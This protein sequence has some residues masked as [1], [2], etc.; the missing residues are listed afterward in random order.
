[1]DSNISGMTAPTPSL[2]TRNRTTCLAS[3]LQRFKPSSSAASTTTGRSSLSQV[4]NVA[5]VLVD[6]WDSSL[7]CNGQ[8]FYV[9]KHIF[10]TVF[11]R[12]R[13]VLDITSNTET[14]WRF[15]VVCWPP[16]TAAGG[17]RL[18]TV[19]W[20][21][22]PC[23]RRVG[24]LDYA[25]LWSQRCADNRMWPPAK[26]RSCLRIRQVVLLFGSV[27]RERILR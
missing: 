4:H 13:Q 26:G 27:Q 17:R 16:L 22:Q 6:G 5:M 9:H 24:V 11:S 7:W 10:F 1:M 21:D 23:C 20:C 15:V 3:S 25:G 18:A 2:C 12:F 14:S 19:C 8:T